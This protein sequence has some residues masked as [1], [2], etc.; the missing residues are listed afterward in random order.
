[1]KETLKAYRDAEKEVELAKERYVLLR[2]RLGK[3]VRDERKRK[4]LTITQIAERCGISAPYLY[5]F[6]L[7]RRGIR[8]DL[9]DSLVSAVSDFPYG[10]G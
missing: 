8:E 10:K 9:I 5:D 3:A 2:T 7:G 6:E 1:M 4:R